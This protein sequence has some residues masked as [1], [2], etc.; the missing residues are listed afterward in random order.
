MV[1]FGD[2]NFVR[3]KKN[4][5]LYIPIWHSICFVHNATDFAHDVHHNILTQIWKLH[6][7]IIYKL[8]RVALCKM[9]H[10]HTFT[11]LYQYLNI[12]SLHKFWIG[13][14]RVWIVNVAKRKRSRQA[15]IFV[16]SENKVF[17]RNRTMCRNFQPC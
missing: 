15:T 16:V 9:L 4:L 13:F 10:I 6:V 3:E 14:N 5:H 1:D 2:Y 17:I 8:T 12:Y 11:S 7:W